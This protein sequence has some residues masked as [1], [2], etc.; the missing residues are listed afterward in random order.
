MCVFRDSI[1][2]TY[3]K[4]KGRYLCCDFSSIS[5]IQSPGRPSGLMHMITLKH[6]SSSANAHYGYI[7]INDYQ[8]P[9]LE[10]VI[11]LRM[12]VRSRPIRRISIL[13]LEASCCLYRPRA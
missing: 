2:T 9:T 7:G 11:D 5:Q 4:F 6:A 1:T 10:G 12:E 3:S 13:I 8:L